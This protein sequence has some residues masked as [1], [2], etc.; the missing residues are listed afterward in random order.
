MTTFTTDQLANLKK[1]YAR[2][3][4]RVREG[5]TWIEYQSMKQMR[6]AIELMETEL[7]I[8]HANKPRGVR[9]VRFGTVK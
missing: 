1:A 6:E 9:R 8:E 2:G 3:V 4:L 5:D 7:G